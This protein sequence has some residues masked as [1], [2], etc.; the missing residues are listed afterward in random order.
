MPQGEMASP[1]YANPRTPRQQDLFESR[2]EREFYR[3]YEPIRKLTG[4]GPSL[5]D[6]D[7]PDA[8][9]MH[10]PSSSPD[11]SLTAFCQL[12][13]LRLG[14]RRAMM[15]FFDKH[16]AY[17]LAEATRTLS[18]Q[19]DAV[20]DIEDELWLGHTVI[21]RGYS[22]CEHTANLPAN[23]GSN[24]GDLN[25]GGIHIINDL[26]D[27]VRFCDRPFV[28]DGPNARFY[29]GV[30]I[31]TPKGIN[32]GAY[33]VLDDKV[34]D[35]IDEKSITF[36]RD[37]ATTIM[38]HLEMVRGRAEYMRGTRMVDGLGA[39]VAG[40]SDAHT[41]DGDPGAAARQA[42]SAAQHA[43]SLLPAPV[44]S[45]KF[46][47]L[48]GSESTQNVN[49]TSS[50]TQQS[51]PRKTSVGTSS[52]A[53]ATRS[54]VTTPAAT[55][56]TATTTTPSDISSAR[57]SKCAEDLRDQIVAS[58]V[59]TTFERAARLVR[60]AVEVDGAIFLDAA[61]VR[62]A[63][64]D[65]SA[66]RRDS[67][68]QSSDAVTSAADATS[69][70]DES[71]RSGAIYDSE[72]KT[73]FCPVMAS[74]GFRSK[75]GVSQPHLDDNELRVDVTDKFLRSLLRRYAR[76]KIWHFDED[77]NASSEDESS[78]GSISTEHSGSPSPSSKSSTD[79]ISVRKKNR[80]RSR[81]EETREIQRIFPRVR[82]LVITGMWDQMRG[83][84]FAA[85][86]M[87]SYS[88]LRVFSD[89]FLHFVRAFN[90]VIL[91]EVH[92]LEAQNSDRAK[93]DF[94]SSISHELRSPLHGILGTVEC[95]QE[96]H[97]SPHSSNLVSQIEVCGRTLLD[98]VNH[99]LDYSK[100]NFFSNSKGPQTYSTNAGP[101][102]LPDANSFN[103]VGTLSLDANVS[104]DRITEEVVETA[105]YSFCYSRDKTA[106]LSRN[107]EFILEIDRSSGLDWGCRIPI[108]GWKR[109]CV[110]LVSN[111]LK[112]TD[113]GYIKVSLSTA[114]V[115]RRKRL[116]A[117]FTVIDTGRGMSK[118]FVESH[119]FSAFRQEDSFTEGSGLG[120]SLVW[121]IVKALGG[122]IDVQSEKAIGTTIVVTV[123]LERSLLGEDESRDDERFSERQR[124]AGIKVGIPE[125]SGV[126]GATVG[127][128]VQLANIEKTCKQ[129]GLQ[130]QTAA[131]SEL[132]TTDILLI[133]EAGARYLFHEHRGGNTAQ[134]QP[135]QNVLGIKPLIVLCNTIISARQLRASSMVNL[136]SEHAEFVPQPGGPEKLSKAVQACLRNNRSTGH[137]D[138]SIEHARSTA[139][140]KPEIIPNLAANGFAFPGQLPIRS[141]V[142][143]RTRSTS[144]P[145]ISPK[146][147]RWKDPPKVS[148]KEF[149][150]AD[151]PSQQSGQLRP[152]PEHINGLV[153]LGAEAHTPVNEGTNLAENAS[154]QLNTD[155]AHPGLP[156]LLVDDNR[157]NL[158]LLVT[159]AQKHNHPQ[160]TAQDGLQAVES[161]KAAY[162]ASALSSKDAISMVQ[163]VQKHITLERPRVILMDINMPVLDG[164]G[165]TRQ[166]RQFEQ[167]YGLEPAIIIALTGLGNAEA[168]QEAYNSGVNLFLTK[169]VR[170]KELTAILDGIPRE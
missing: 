101:R 100:I 84:W 43:P 136:T 47:S 81:V 74:S 72:D 64:L 112:Y 138:L 105:V 165:A 7:D 11:R 38:T 156:M 97:V 146:T 9:R 62:Y 73:R 70:E 49:G 25:A 2:R 80:K 142:L 95:L 28:L 77:G 139:V 59:R 160:T 107:V 161:Y 144:D 120:M 3:Y 149:E 24:Q 35:G 121:K 20:H 52:T 71:T 55:P 58:N 30:P 26:R 151:S 86:I 21:P 113:E 98:I 96:E 106:I 168:Q 56:P 87:W 132:H 108:G 60:E 166:I 129:L 53:S 159:Y 118:D 124:L 143:Q 78:E 154:R 158:Q 48:A 15:F 110:N 40:A 150:Q 162:R 167:Q 153:Q 152:P 111:A 103:P 46:A 99:L 51:A 34:R 17:V 6:L 22:V 115:K 91:A 8:V 29:A 65:V 164:F 127:K 125:I 69:T 50:K 116:N 155:K 157:I 122:K 93:V 23:Q 42:P 133:T 33:C 92:R 169:P 89:D 170:L 54:G 44:Q 1:A 39:F 41:S 5:C 145:P 131:L 102:P 117:V 19:N 114:P 104:L 76:G 148:S 128:S 140:A 79:S 82:G 16:Y 137:H 90:D 75:D 32:I 63:S 126:E 109:I 135:S 119:L 4:T 88:P 68:D 18:L 13:A 27:D 134:A 130:V 163:G 85:S 37:M 147:L 123:P 31:T 12:G 66:E 36:L 67:Q 141:R 83:R 10:L 61:P 14:T 45:L 94:I 57:I